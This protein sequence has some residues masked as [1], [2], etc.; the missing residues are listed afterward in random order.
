LDG[1]DHDL[2]IRSDTSLERLAKL[3]P[4]FDRNAGTITAGNASPLTDGASAVLLMSEER[5]RKEGREPLA[6]I[7]AFEYAAIDPKDGLLMAPGLA[8]PRLFAKTG[9]K[10][11]DMDIVEIHEAF[12]AQVACNLRAWEQGWKEKAIGAVDKEKLNPLGG[13][14]AIGHPFA[15]TGGRM[16]TS[17]ANEM[18]RRNSKYGL[19]SIC[20]A[21]AMAAAMILQRD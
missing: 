1:I 14:I 18:K 3:R 21:G 12:G 16:V 19:I 11:S 10:L 5:A 15:A 6:F 4:V 2:I 9:L 8:V 17:L 13:S 7:K 20:A